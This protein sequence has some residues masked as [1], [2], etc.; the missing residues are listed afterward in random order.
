MIP[1]RPIR[2]GIFTFDGATNQLHRE[3]V[4]VHLEAQPAQVL[5]MLLTHAGQLVT[6]DELRQA[7]WGADTFVDFDRGLNY[8]VAQIRAALK[9]SAESPRFVRTLPKRG[10]Q[11]IAPVETVAVPELGTVSKP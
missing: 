6:R 11:F 10:Y 7:V 9:D 3:G 5:A 2:F 4:P 8:C 1:S